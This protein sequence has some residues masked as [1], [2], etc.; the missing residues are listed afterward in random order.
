[1][2]AP[3][4][5]GRTQTARCPNSGIEQEIPSNEFLA[6]QEGTHGGCTCGHDDCDGWV[7]WDK[8]VGVEE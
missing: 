4:Y 6:M 2:V 1:M 3:S 7:N 8:I 5:N